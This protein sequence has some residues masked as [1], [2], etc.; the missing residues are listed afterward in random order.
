MCDPSE[1]D[2]GERAD[3]VAPGMDEGE[4]TVRRTVSQTQL[5][6]VAATH[7]EGPIPPPAILQGYEDVIPGSAER[8]L[9]MA[10]QESSYR[11]GL[12]TK[13]LNADISRSNR[14]L[15]LGWV[16]ALAFLVAATMMVL[17]G[18]PVPGTIFGTLDLAGLVGVFVYGKWSGERDENQHPEPSE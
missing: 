3:V 13:M 6:A 9:R 11:H 5:A 16:V 12:T 15:W 10:E 17:G 4:E 7:F 8:I 18:H 2:D 14:G 1:G